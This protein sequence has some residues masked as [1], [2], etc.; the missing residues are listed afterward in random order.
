MNFE[1]EE[2][3]EGFSSVTDKLKRV[4]NK[5]VHTLEVNGFKLPIKENLV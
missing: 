3:E 4:I 2:L 5:C 1:I